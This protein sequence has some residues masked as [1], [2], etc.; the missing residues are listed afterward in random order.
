MIKRIG[1]TLLLLQFS[2]PLLSQEREWGNWLM[3]F[4]Q[5]RLS[6]K[7]SIHSELQYRN[8]TLA[9]VNIEQLLTRLG[10]NYHLK[11]NA[12]VTAGIGYISSHS[13]DGEETS[14]VSEEFRVW[15]QFISTQNIGRVKLEHRYRL[16]QRWIGDVYRNRAR[17]RIMLFIPFNKPKMEA[18]TWFLGLYDE[19]FLNTK[20]AFFDRNR[21]YGAIG[22]QLNKST[23]FQL[24]ILNQ[25]LDPADKMYL[26]LAVVYNP[27]FRKR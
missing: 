16:E 15:Q 9:P 1:L 7:Y 27:D 19:V 26:Q 20:S 11:P 12:M 8:H 6:E 5:N 25:A 2:T 4:G 3:Y 24:G 18:G 17:Y 14:L 13:Y 22:Y 21:L 23:G 10:V